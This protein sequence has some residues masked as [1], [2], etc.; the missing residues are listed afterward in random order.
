MLQ[1]AAQTKTARLTGALQWYGDEVSHAAISDAWWCVGCQRTHK[2][3][4]M[5]VGYSILAGLTYEYCHVAKRKSKMEGVT[6]S[7]E[8]QRQIRE[9]YD[10]LPPLATTGK[11]AAS[12]ELERHSNASRRH[13]R[14]G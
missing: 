9:W 10:K 11:P 4:N 1:Q 7:G 5:V 13:G 14:H 8:R 6:V 12:D 2:R 3:N